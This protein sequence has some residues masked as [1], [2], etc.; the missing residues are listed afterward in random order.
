MMRILKVLRHY[1]TAL[2]FSGVFAFIRARLSGAHPLFKSTVPGVRHPVYVRIGTTDVSVLRQVLL[3][4]HYELPI[5]IAPALI[6]DAGAN[7]GLSAVYFANKYPGA[8]IVALEPE[9]S[10]FAVLQKNAAPYPQIKPVQAALWAEEK[11]I[12]LIDPD[13]GHHGFQTVELGVGG[14]GSSTSVRALTLDG[15]MS[16][17][18]FDTVDILKIDIE[19]AEKEVFENSS[20]WVDRVALIMA[21]LHDNIKPGCTAAFQQAT[22]GFPREFLKGETVMRMR[23]MADH[24]VS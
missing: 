12:G 1:H 8:T 14:N 3:E 24:C 11:Q 5:Q 20:I 18:G 6:L 7:I 16:S 15:L 19:G 17:M 22:K 13:F 9:A 23:K 2:G 4:K 21:E 10:N